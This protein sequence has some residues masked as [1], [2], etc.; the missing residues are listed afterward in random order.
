MRKG[1]SICLVGVLGISVI[2]SGCKNKDQSRQNFFMYV[3][4]EWIKNNP[5]PATEP[6]WGSFSEL[7]EKNLR[8]LHKILDSTSALSAAP[9]G[10][11]AQLIGDFF[12]SGMD[13]AGI[14]KAGLEPLKPALQKIDAIRDSKDLMET[15]AY[16]QRHGIFTL[17]GIMVDQDARKSDQYALYAMQGGL[18]LPNKDYYFA[19]DAKSES[20]RKAYK[21]HVANMLVLTGEKPGQSVADAET[22]MKIETSLAGASMGPVELRDPV[23]TYNKWTL[24][25]VT[26]TL[27]AMNW[28][29]Y[30][31]DAGIP[32]LKSIIISQPAFFKKVNQEL[33]NTGPADWKIYLRWHLVHNTAWCLNSSFVNEHFNFYQKKIKGIKALETRWK[34]VQ[35]MTDMALGDALGKEYVKKNFSP[36][37]KQKVLLMINNLKAAL[38]DRIDR[39]EW[40]S[41]AT[42]DSA[43]EK[44][45]TLIVKIGYPDKWKRYDGLKIDRTS[46]MANVMRSDSFEYERN[47][48]KINK[49]V[50]RTEWMMTPA[51]TNA[52][53]NPTLNEIVFPAGI[54]QPPFFD[55]AADDALNYGAI[56]AVIGHE[57]THGFDDQGRMYDAYGNL[58]DWWTREDSKKFIDKSRILVR[59]FNQY[60]IAGEHVNGELTLGE[61]IADLGGLTIAYEAFQQSRK[62]KGKEKDIDGYSPDQRFFI[63][64]ARIWRSNDRPEFLV[65]LLK[66]NPHSP[67]IYRVN[68]P[69]SNMP[70]FYKAFDVKPGDSMLAPDSMRAQ[71]W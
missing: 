15:I 40:M 31:R 50:D 28:S 35:R 49:P 68:G 54:L 58:S 3:N 66:N 62:N 55:P 47:I 29:S 34:R 21:A 8:L 37:A 42:K 69:L 71:I 19:K 6:S 63:G 30:L 33:T 4:G 32:A 70:A 41:P 11:D 7:T 10:S 65:Q 45:K 12:A 52:Y 23:K 57:L 61:N 51:T 27:P 44:L 64:W 38:T 36:E 1:L 26:D 59:Q 14:E 46:Y 60:V 56:G 18:G 20:I 67:G 25:E 39:L 9:K 22:V 13:S 2:I 53:Y 16:L 5:I 48:Q 17:F 24:Q 43:K